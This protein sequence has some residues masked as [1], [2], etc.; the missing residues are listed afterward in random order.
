MCT[1]KGEPLTKHLSPSSLSNLLKNGSVASLHTLTYHQTHALPQKPNSHADTTIQNL[2]TQ[3]Q[4]LFDI[5]KTLPPSRTQDHHIPLLDE[6][7]TINVKP[8][9]YPHYQKQIMTTLISDMLSSG[10]IRPSQSPFSSPVLLVKKKD[11]TWRFCVD[12]RALNAVTV[13][14]RFPIPTIDELLD[15]R[16]GAMVFSK[17]DLRSGYH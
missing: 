13:R 10:V 5:P 6:N 14:D 11:G 7:Q 3:F 8:Y 4:P 17:I 9:R 2:L 12:Y 16:H 15:E 1:L